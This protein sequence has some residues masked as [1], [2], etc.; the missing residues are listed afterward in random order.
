[1]WHILVFAVLCCAK[2]CYPIFFSV[3]KKKAGLGK[4]TNQLN[5]IITRAMPK[6]ASLVS[7]CLLVFPHLG[8]N[9][10]HF[11]VCLTGSP[12]LIIE[13]CPWHPA[14]LLPGWVDN[15][16]AVPCLPLQTCQTALPSPCSRW[17]YLK[18]FLISSALYTAYHI[19]DLSK[20]WM[21]KF[22]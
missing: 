14:S 11:Q 8:L 13:V 5:S 7:R 16:S 3:K 21:L 9:A 12:V 22:I 6:H 17:Q 15:P 18:Y 1:M 10:S 20:C 19:K 4:P 2:L